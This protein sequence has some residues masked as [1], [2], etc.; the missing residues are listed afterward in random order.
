MLNLDEIATLREV[1]KWA[2]AEGWTAHRRPEPDEEG[3]HHLCREWVNLEGTRRVHVY[4][5]MEAD[6][7]FSLLVYYKN[8][9]A[10]PLEVNSVK[11]AIDLL[12]ALDVISPRM[13]SIW[14]LGWNAGYHMS[15]ILRHDNALLQP[16]QVLPVVPSKDSESL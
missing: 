5:D 7:N 4:L 9:A 6:E 11:E 13:S 16:T 8:N 15:R 2:H 10:C 14:K 1:F 12:A 3:T